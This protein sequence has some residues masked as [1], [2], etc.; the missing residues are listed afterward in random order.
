MDKIL[1]I[2]VL[3]VVI[4]GIVI[5]WVWFVLFRDS[6]VVFGVSFV[7]LFFYGVVVLIIVCFCVLGFVILIVFMVGIGCSV[8]MGVFFKNG[9]VL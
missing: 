8:K 6:V 7:F 3:V 5:F 1:G 9:M 2:F 4:L